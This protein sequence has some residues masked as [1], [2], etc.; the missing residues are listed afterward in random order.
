M[1]FGDGEEG[2]SGQNQEKRE[3]LTAKLTHLRVASPFYSLTL[4]H[5]E[6]AE[7]PKLR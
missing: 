5:K 3:D 7:H 6:I 4:A 1:N 2:E